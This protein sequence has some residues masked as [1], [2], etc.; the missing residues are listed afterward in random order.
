ML[1]DRPGCSPREAGVEG[2][3]ALAWPLA[4]IV[5]EGEGNGAIHGEGVGGGEGAVKHPNHWS[6]PDHCA[7]KR[8]PMTRMTRYIPIDGRWRPVGDCQG[9]VWDSV[10]DSQ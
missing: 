8:A 7:W 1:S 4:E 9:V 5:E 10:L 6:K 2:R 3:G